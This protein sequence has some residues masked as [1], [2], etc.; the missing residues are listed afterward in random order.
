MFGRNPTRGAYL[1]E[2]PLRTGRWHSRVRQLPEALGEFPVA[3][4][5]DEIGRQAL[6]C[7]R[8]SACLNVSPVY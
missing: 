1:P 4:L 7:I 5:A 3:T 8:C 6:R 2:K